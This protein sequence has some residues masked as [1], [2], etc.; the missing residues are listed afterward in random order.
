MTDLLY[1]LTRTAFPILFLTIKGEDMFLY[2]SACSSLYTG[3]R[4]KLRFGAPVAFSR[5]RGQGKNSKAAMRLLIITGEC[6]AT[7]R[8]I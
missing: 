2:L 3:Y 6:Y 5:Q 7:S 8:H 4:N 1:V